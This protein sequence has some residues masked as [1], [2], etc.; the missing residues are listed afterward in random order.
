MVQLEQDKTRAK[1]SNKIVL[2]SEKEKDTTEQEVQRLHN[3]LQA[4]RSRTH[5]TTTNVALDSRE[6]TTPKKG[7]T[8][9]LD[10]WIVYWSLGNCTLTVKIRTTRE[11]Y[12]LS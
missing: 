4:E 9:P 6:E 8:V 10:Q 1:T 3:L 7:K 2:D 11:Y 12:E 5:T